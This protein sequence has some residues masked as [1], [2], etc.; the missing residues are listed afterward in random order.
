MT[1][2]MKGMLA[3]SLLL[4]TPA[5]AEEAHHTPSATAG[6]SAADI[7][8]VPSTTNTIPGGDATGMMGADMMKMMKDMMASHAGMMRGMMSEEGRADGA[9]M[10]EMMSPEHMEGRIAFLRTELK[11]TEA[12]QP[13]WEAV[14]EVLRANSAASKGMLPAMMGGM[15][16]PDA[17]LR[18]LPQRLSDMERMLSA[19]LDGLHRLNAAL[20]P[21]YASLGETQKATA[22]D[23][24]IPM[25]VM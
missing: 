15:T 25:G 8:P 6:D 10:R 12:Q 22:D 16:Q 5:L 13:L 23:L 11:I 19:R 17:S 24:L 18:P 20:E 4:S 2:L 9:P 1:T 3:A 21:F 14:A 7:V